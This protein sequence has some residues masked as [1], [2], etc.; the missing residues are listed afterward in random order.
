MRKTLL[1]TTA[2]AALV[3]FTA[4]AAA[5]NTSTGGE[6]SKAMPSPGAQQEQKANPSG[7]A[8]KNGPSGGAMKNG[9]QSSE[10]KAAS[11][12][13][14]SAQSATPG[15]KGGN[16]EES[17][18]ENSKQGAS[19]NQRMGETPEQNKAKSQRGA[20]EEHGKI[21]RGA[22]EERGMKER[23]AQEERTTKE[24]GARGES[25]TNVNV[26]EHGGT[27]RDSRATSVRLSQE[28]RTRIGE[29]IGKGHGRRVSTN[30]HFS[31]SVGAKVP[32]SVHIEVL[33]EDIVRIVPE[34]EGFDYVLL[35]D[36]I[37]I[38]DPDSLEIVAVIPA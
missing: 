16:K 24:R 27:S 4:L 20:Q 5:Q 10:N 29:I 15:N 38:I 14:R 12:P 31:V 11:Q 21:Q 18:Q 26:S 36:Q 9:G 3:G 13:N 28:Q 37:L 23:N 35:G 19:S 30:E 32:R 2:A 7:G 6:S 8:M 17:A 34:Y 25:N 1:A 22:R 33:P